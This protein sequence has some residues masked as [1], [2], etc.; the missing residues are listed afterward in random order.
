MYFVLV[1]S[2]LL[3]MGTILFFVAKLSYES[4]STLL[5]HRMNVWK[6]LCM[7]KMCSLIY[8][9]R[10]EPMLYQ[11]L[12]TSLSLLFD[13]KWLA[14]SMGKKCGFLRRS[15]IQQSKLQFWAFSNCKCNIPQ[16]KGCVQNPAHA[17]STFLPNTNCITVS[18]DVSDTS[19]LPLNWKD[20][21]SI[22]T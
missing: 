22:I 7:G 19:R 17:V 14:A 15:S 20:A 1:K 2:C 3:L 21:Q 16:Y 9:L 13:T 5:R 6:G 10:K 4:R 18:Q 11:C 12:A 8:Q